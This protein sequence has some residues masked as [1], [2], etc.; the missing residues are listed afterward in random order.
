MDVVLGKNAT[1]RTLLD[2]PVYNYIVWTFNNGDGQVNLATLTGSNLNVENS[3]FTGRVSIDEASG[4]LLLTD[5]TSAD[6]GDYGILI[7]GVPG[8]T[9][10]DDIALR[11][12][13]ESFRWVRTQNLPPPPRTSS[14]CIFQ[15]GAANS[16]FLSLF[17]A[18]LK[19]TLFSGRH[20][21]TYT[22]TLVFDLF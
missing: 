11:V 5:T 17:C 13:G 14:S 9:L 19:V 16:G 10:T 1:L 20:A 21:Y 4:S 8:G 12:L 15:T 3:Q 18:P 7:L 6:S 22:Y 2:K